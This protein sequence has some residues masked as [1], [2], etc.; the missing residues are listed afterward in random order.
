[1]RFQASLLGAVAGPALTA[2][3]V[4]AAPAIGDAPITP[5]GN[6]GGGALVAPP[7]PIDGAGNA[8]LALRALPKR[9]LELE[10]TVRG[11]CAGGDISAA[12]KVLADGS[13]KADGTVSQQPDPALKITTTYKLSG[14]FTSRSAAEGT[15]TATLE[16]S[17]E[18][19]KTTCRS[20]TVKFAVRRPTGGLGEPGA[21]E[22]AFYYGTTTQRST[23]PNRPIVLRV[24]ASGARLSRALFG[25]SVKCSDDRVAIGIEAP[26][27]DV[28]IDSR[29]RVA[30]HERYEFTQGEAVVHVDDHFTA[31]LGTRGA[32]GTFSLSSRAAD[33]ASGRTIQTCK[34]GTVRWRAAR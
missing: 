34:S 22:A 6:F 11:R 12:T 25:E 2:A 8:I 20:G 13:F 1:V 19:K 14:R 31:E 9:M 17:L 32:R 21:P 18:G 24:S 27:T 3:A 26:R 10:A 29:G 4:L 15:L 7:R 5:H 30:D 28:P 16:R 33:R 23:G